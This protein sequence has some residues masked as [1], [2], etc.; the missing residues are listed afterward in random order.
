MKKTLTNRLYIKKRMFTLKMLEGSSLDDHLDEFNKVCYTLETID[1]ALSDE[2]EALLLISSL[3]KSYEHFVDASMYGR[4][5]LTLDKAKSALS[6]KK[7]QGK[8]ESLGNGT[9]EGLTTKVRPEGKKKN[10]GKNKERSKNLK[11]FLCHKEGHF[12]KDCP[13]RKH[14]K[15]GHN[16]DV[17]LQRIEEMNQLVFVLQ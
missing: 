14:K 12:K 16:G 1:A 5:T 6:T 13:E 7:L 2:D 9:G 17:M 4:Q 10:R 3:P 11:C 8:Q 15:K